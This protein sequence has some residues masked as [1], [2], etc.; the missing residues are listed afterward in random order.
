MWSQSLSRTSMLHLFR[1]CLIYDGAMMANWQQFSF[2][3]PTQAS[4]IFNNNP[5]YYA[6]FD[7]YLF[8]TNNA[9]A[10][11]DSVKFRIMQ[12]LLTNNQTFRTHLANL[13][14]PVDFIQTGCGHDINCL[15]AEQ[16]LQSASF[17]Q[18]LMYPPTSV[19]NEDLPEAVSLSQNYPNPFNPTT[20]I[21]YSLSSQERVGVRS[22]QVLLAVYDLLGREVATLVNEAKEPGEYSVV[23][24]GSNLSSGVYFYRLRA[25]EFVETKKLVIMK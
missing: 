5:Q 20:T 11:R 23:F 10:L 3:L 4:S 24:D 1:A 8:A 21:N 14:I 15:M 6:L 18:S 25:G 2:F 9:A 12:A 17:I 7:P 19:E 22:Q 16:G 13:Q